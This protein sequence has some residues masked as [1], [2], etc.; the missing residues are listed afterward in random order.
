MDW[1]LSELRR[2]TN[3]IFYSGRRCILSFHLSFSPPLRNPI[4]WPRVHF[5]GCLVAY[6]ARHAT[7]SEAQKDDVDIFPYREYSCE[8][9]MCL[10]A[11][12][13][14]SP[15]GLK[16]AV[17]RETMGISF[18]AEEVCGEL[19]A[20]FVHIFIIVSASTRGI[21]ALPFL[22]LPITKD[23][24]FHCSPS[25]KNYFHVDDLKENR[26]LCLRAFWHFCNSH[27]GNG[28]IDTEIVLPTNCYIFSLL[29]FPSILPGSFARVF[30]AFARALWCNISS[31]N[32]AT[33]KQGPWFRILGPQGIYPSTLP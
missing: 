27:G 5:L 32:F 8:E 7:S 2:Y 9:V 13:L 4:F 14:D 18:G 26:C 12:S 10:C 19:V 22:P 16:M 23:L 1:I 17:S 11:S 25:P 28:D 21:F 29:F 20:Q 33:P 15:G 24:P 6:C 3:L 30:R 31:F